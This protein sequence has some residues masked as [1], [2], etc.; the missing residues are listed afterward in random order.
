MFNI[1]PIKIIRSKRKTIALHIDQNASLVVKAPQRVSLDYIHR[2]IEEKKEW[3]QQKISAMQKHTGKQYVHGEAFLYL[4]KS[5]ALQVGDYKTIMAHN[6]FLFFPQV[7]LFRAKKEL[8]GWYIRQAKEIITRRVNWYAEKMK[9]TYAGI[10][11]SDTRSRWGSCSVHNELQFNWRL[12]LS[13][14]HII[15]YVVVHELAHTIE[16]NHTW[17][18]WSKVRFVLPAYKQW[19]KWLQ[20]HGNKLVV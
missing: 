18:F 3:I 14:L 6:T 11:F 2:L 5:Y 10:S 12:I 15:D 13:P 17:K 1:P 19:R 7:L 8:T 16:K 9:T 4:G 20:E